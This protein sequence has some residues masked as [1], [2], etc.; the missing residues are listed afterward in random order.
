VECAISMTDV[1][2]ILGELELDEGGGADDDLLADLADVVGAP[3]ASDAEPAAPATEPTPAEAELDEL[4]EAALHGVE[5]AAAVADQREGEHRAAKIAALSA[6]WAERIEAE[7]AATPGRRKVARRRL[8]HCHPDPAM[9]ALFA[10][11]ERKQDEFEAKQN[12]WKNEVAA[13]HAP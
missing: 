3:A 6:A 9:R 2:R 4:D 5:S 11:W 7:R 12:R 10:Q 8:K 13:F 1:E